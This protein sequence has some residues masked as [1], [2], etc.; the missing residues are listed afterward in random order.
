VKLPCPSCG[1][2]VQG[3]DIDL[4]RCLAVCRACNEVVPLPQVVR[5]DRQGVIV[6][7]GDAMLV[8]REVAG[9]PL[10]AYRPSHIPLSETRTG[11]RIVLRLMPSLSTGLVA[12]LTAV[13][14]NLLMIL[15]LRFALS[16][17]GSILGVLRFMFPV[18]HLIV[19]LFFLYMA[20]CLLVNRIEMTVTPTKFQFTHRPLWQGGDFSE[21]LRNL[22]CFVDNQHM[23]RARHERWLRQAISWTVVALT[24]DNRSLEMDLYLLERDHARYVALRLNRALDEMRASQQ[25]PGATTAPAEEDV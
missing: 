5:V 23:A 9:L 2:F 14:W 3:P 25:R 17:D 21:P 11:Q 13:V 22:R 20:V 10:Y 4:S 8:A 12:L 18:L 16:S 7:D 15:W 24:R 1:E 19:G 6:H